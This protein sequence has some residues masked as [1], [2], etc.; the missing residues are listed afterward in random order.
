MDAQGYHGKL[1]CPF[2]RV[3]ARGG[4]NTVIEGAEEEPGAATK[5]AMMV[6]DMAGVG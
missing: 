1:G 3:L 6:K 4:G 5:G 2:L